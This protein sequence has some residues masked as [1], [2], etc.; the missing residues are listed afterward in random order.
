MSSHINST[1]TPTF[2]FVYDAQGESNITIERLNQLASP[3][4]TTDLTGLVALSDLNEEIVTLLPKV[5]ISST[6]GAPS[7]GVSVVSI[8]VVDSSAASNP[9]LGTY[10]FT[11][12]ASDNNKGAVDVTNHLAVN[13]GT[14]LITASPAGSVL[15]IQTDSSGLANITSTKAS[16]FV[17]YF[18]VEIGNVVYSAQVTHP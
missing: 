10:A 4:V 8:Q 1:V 16:G 9:I 5:T 12:W 7:S 2:Q 15:Y 6:D 17:N 11:V 14:E 3:N 18:M 13:T